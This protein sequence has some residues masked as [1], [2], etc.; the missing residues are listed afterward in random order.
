MFAQ[1][2]Q[3]IYIVCTIMN[4]LVQCFITFFRSDLTFVYNFYHFLICMSTML[5][6][7]Q[8]MSG[9]LYKQAVIQRFFLYKK[10]AMLVLCLR[11]AAC[12]GQMEEEDG[13]TPCPG[14][15]RRLRG[16]NR[17]ACRPLHSCFPP[18][19]EFAPTTAQPGKGLPPSALLLLPSFV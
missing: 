19:H 7:M 15:G 14:K 4:I 3:E 5:R 11:Y 16:D 12:G 17:R 6:K 18:C 13:D 8:L 2:L 1:L 10:V 9:I